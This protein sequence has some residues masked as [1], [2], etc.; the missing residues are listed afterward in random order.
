M[1]RFR[2]NIRRNFLIEKI[3]VRGLETPRRKFI[4]NTKYIQTDILNR[5]VKRST[6]NGI[7]ETFIAIQLFI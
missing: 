7:D 3:R 2:N 6:T 4:R 1:I 5:N